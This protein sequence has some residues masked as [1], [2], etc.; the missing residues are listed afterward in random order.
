MIKMKHSE[1]SL[2]I[3]KL[4]VILLAAFFIFFL[5]AAPF[6]FNWYCYDILGTRGDRAIVLRTVFY[7]C[8]PSAAV[9]LIYTFKFLK[10]LERGEVFTERTVKYLK[11]LSYACLSVVPLS[12]PLCFFFLAGLPIPAAAGFMW[13]ILRII[14]NAF[15]YGTQ[16]K[17]ENDLTV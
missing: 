12:I 9:T 10:N 3:T 16:I 11:I 6:V 5:F 7:A 4:I 17:N 8:S 2:K 15:E 14:K 13:L 1:K